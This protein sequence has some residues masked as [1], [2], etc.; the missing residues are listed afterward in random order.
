M[1]ARSL[2]V[3]A[4]SVNGLGRVAVPARVVNLARR[5]R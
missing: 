2:S 4:Y 1:V 5:D 3:V